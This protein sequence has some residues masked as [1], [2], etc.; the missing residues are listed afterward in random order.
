MKPVSVYVQM[1][2]PLLNMGVRGLASRRIE[3]LASDFAEVVQSM[4]VT[5]L[6]SEEHEAGSRVNRCPSPALNVP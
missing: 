5:A 6:P 2:S 3:Q 1:C 4:S